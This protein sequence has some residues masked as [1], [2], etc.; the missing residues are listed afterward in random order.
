[1]AAQVRKA[2]AINNQGHVVGDAWGPQNGAWLFARAYIYDHRTGEITDLNDL[3]P[4]NRG[5]QL[6]F[7]NDINDAGQIVG[8]GL[9]GGELHAFVLNPSQ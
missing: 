9:I 8:Q 7:D 4:R 1:M 2:S 5:W 6:V 3:I